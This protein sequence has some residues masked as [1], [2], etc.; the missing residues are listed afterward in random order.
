MHAGYFFNYLGIF[1]L[2]FRGEEV[3]PEGDYRRA[4]FCD[5][6]PLAVN[7][8]RFIGSDADGIQHRAALM[9]NVVTGG[10]PGGERIAQVMRCPVERPVLQVRREA[11]DM[12]QLRG[13]NGGQ[14]C[15]VLM[16]EAIKPVADTEYLDGLMGADVRH[17]G[18]P[19]F[20]RGC[21]CF[22]ATQPTARCCRQASAAC[23]RVFPV[24]VSLLLLK[25]PLRFPACPADV[26]PR[27]A[28]RRGGTWPS[29]QD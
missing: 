26:S 12:Y 4:F 15:A 24:M 17:C 5:L 20:R 3:R 14:L 11:A 19:R 23:V 7:A 16:H 13:K 28:S 8:G 27:L 18:L 9:I 29:I 25:A 21:E 6:L 2:F 1:R 10:Q 22:P